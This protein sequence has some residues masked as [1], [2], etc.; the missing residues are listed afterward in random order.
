MDALF[1]PG[2]VLVSLNAWGYLGW[3]VDKVNNLVQQHISGHFGDVTSK[4]WDTNNAL[5]ENGARKG[6]IRSRYLVGS[7]Y[8]V[9]ITNIGDK[10][11]TVMFEQEKAYWKLG[12]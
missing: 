10:Y 7:W 11:T 2:N 3:S 1:N 8:I 5:I 9:V 6:F 4:K 12:K